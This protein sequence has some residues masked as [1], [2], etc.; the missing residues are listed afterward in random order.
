FTAIH[1]PGVNASRAIRL[2]AKLGP[3]TRTR[4]CTRLYSAATTTPRVV[5]TTRRAPGPERIKSDGGCAHSVTLSLG[6]MYTVAKNSVSVKGLT[7]HL[8]SNP[9]ISESRPR[10]VAPRASFQPR[11]AY[12][13]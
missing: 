3:R 9:G 10:L 4:P 1:R 8:D 7:S 12:R 2:A 13:Y 11:D 5:R 6:G